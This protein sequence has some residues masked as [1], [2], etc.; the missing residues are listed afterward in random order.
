VGTVAWLW[1][2]NGAAALVIGGSITVSMLAACLIGLAVPT[3]LHR[4][5]LDPRIAAGPVSLALADVFTLLVYLNIA[6]FVL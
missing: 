5:K 2:G 4:F 3:L 1:R 6:T